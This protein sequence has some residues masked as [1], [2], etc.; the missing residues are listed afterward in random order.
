V[1]GFVLD[2]SVTIAWCFEDETNSYTDAVLKDLADTG[3]VV[4]SIWP[5]EVANVLLV[6]ERRNKISKAQSRRFVE[7]LQSLPIAVDDVSVARAWDGILS[8]AREQQLSAYDAAYLEL[9]MREGLPI[10]TSDMA[11]KRAAIRCGVAMRR[12]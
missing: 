9:A 5:L 12:G 2:C 7:L 1:S 8:L 6:A 11:L 10:A 3:A 4:P